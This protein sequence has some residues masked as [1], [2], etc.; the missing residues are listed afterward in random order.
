M[1]PAPP[2]PPRR[3]PAAHRGLVALV[4]LAVLACAVAYWF[5]NPHD[6]FDLKIYVRALRWWAA[7]DP[8]YEYA[9]PDRVQ[10]ALYFTYPP[11]A[12]LLLLPFAALPLGVTATLFTVFTLAAVAVTTWWLVTPLAAARGLPR[13]WLA[14]LAVPLVLLIEPLRETI[15]FGQ[16]NMLLAVLVV[17]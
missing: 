17:G 1:T 3:R 2:S 14:A 13:G 15:M 5:T 4:P 12:A 11:F 16:I 6:F 10:G 8:L 7:G 9:Q